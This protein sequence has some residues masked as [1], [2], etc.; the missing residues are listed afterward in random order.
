[1]TASEN[2][3]NKV[4]EL[5]NRV[6]SNEESVVERKQILN[7]CDE[8]NANPEFA[9][10]GFLVAKVKLIQHKAGKVTD[11]S[12]LAT[13]FEEFARHQPST[14]VWIC[15]AETYLH[16]G[17]AESAVSPLEYAQALGENADV[18]I[19]LSL[20][21]RRL[22]KKD[23][24]KSL[25]YA[26]Q[27]VKLEMTNGKAWGNLGIALL[28]IAGH[29]NIVQASKA[30]KCAIKNGQQNN[31]DVMM[32]LG[33]VNELL[34]D[35]KEAIH[36]YEEAIRI[37]GQWQVAVDSVSRVQSRLDSVM[38]RAELIPKI[39]P[40]KKNK[41]LQ[42]IT[43]DDEYLVVEAP[44]PMEDPSQIIL[45]MNNKSE[46]FA[47]GIIKTMRAYVIP[48]KSV[49][50]MPT[51]E[52]VNLEIKDKQIKYYVIDDMRKVKILHGATPADVPPVSISSSI[53]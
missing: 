43:A 10:N 40:S 18:L 31:A 2:F 34:L 9:S 37:A 38:A 20:C 39:R 6:Q 27:A 48:E 24:Q 19:L 13:E 51:P 46:V 52:F 7:E 36:C 21:Y 45:C 53:A 4:A 33:T 12:V 29:D 23:P 15:L 5:W 17:K 11:L 8:L 44:F 3:A 28:S 14:D 26:K 35:F 25:D 42:R 41:L 30:F 49:L 50:K 22:E 32:N 1:M 16:E 47:F